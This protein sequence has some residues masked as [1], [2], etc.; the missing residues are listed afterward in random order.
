MAVISSFTTSTTA[1]DAMDTLNKMLAD[2]RAL[3]A[4]VVTPISISGTPPTS[5]QVGTAYSFT[6]TTAN[7]TG[8]KTFAL[9]GGPLLA[10]LAFSTS[11]GAITG[12]PTAAGSMPNLVVTVTDSSGSASTTAT[13]VTIAAAASATPFFGSS[14]QT[15]G[16]DSDAV[17]G[18]AA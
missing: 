14:T 9:S 7:G 4:P 8:A 2:I 17:F 1:A 15:F 6:P 5:G 13:S 12:T 18:K 10:G 16:N 3:Q 11:T